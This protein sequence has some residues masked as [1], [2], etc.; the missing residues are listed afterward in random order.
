MLIIRTQNDICF[1]VHDF[2]MKATLQI[3]KIG[4]VDIISGSTLAL[5]H[6]PALGI[7]LNRDLASGRYMILNPAKRVIYNMMLRLMDCNSTDGGYL[8]FVRIVR[9]PL[10]NH[11]YRYTHIADVLLLNSHTKK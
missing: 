8:R 1:T 10:G 11:V 7:F 5:L 4:H 9:Y 2:S 6:S 3:H